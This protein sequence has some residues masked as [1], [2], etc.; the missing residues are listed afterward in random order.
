MLSQVIHQRE[1]SR[2]RVWQIDYPRRR[3]RKPKKAKDHSTVRR[4][5][6]VD[7]L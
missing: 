5:L 4:S 7:Y 1:I 2:Y 3:R 6:V